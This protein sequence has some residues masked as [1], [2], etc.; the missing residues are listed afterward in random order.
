MEKGN[1]TAT[2]TVVAQTQLFIQML[3]QRL[4]AFAAAS[5]TTP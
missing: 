5:Y 2:A 1:T 3:Q 4:A